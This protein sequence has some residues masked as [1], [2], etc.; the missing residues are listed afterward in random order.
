MDNFMATGRGRIKTSLETSW[1]WLAYTNLKHIHA[2]VCQDTLCIGGITEEAG[3]LSSKGNF[4]Y[5]ICNPMIDAYQ[6]LI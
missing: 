3:I 4:I 2:K 6:G 1:I 5:A